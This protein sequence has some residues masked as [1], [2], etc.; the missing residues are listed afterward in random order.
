MNSLGRIQN[1]IE[2]KK[3]KRTDTE[4][5]RSMFSTCFQAKGKDKRDIMYLKSSCEKD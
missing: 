3:K 2:K 5:K 1:K 4:K